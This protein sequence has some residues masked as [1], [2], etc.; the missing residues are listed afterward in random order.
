MNYK[1]NQ[2]NFLLTML[3]CVYNLYGPAIQITHVTGNILYSSKKSEVFRASPIEWQKIFLLCDIVLLGAQMLKEPTEVA[4]FWNH[5]Q[6]V[7]TNISIK[8]VKHHHTY[9]REQY[10]P[11]YINFKV[12]SSI[13][14]KLDSRKAYK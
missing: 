1:P 5:H 3:N 14:L 6:I 11:T 12:N 10:T 9:Y 7:N 2:N 4:T 8:K 13:M